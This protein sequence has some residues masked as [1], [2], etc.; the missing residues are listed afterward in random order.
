MNRAYPYLTDKQL[1]LE[2]AIG[3]LLNG[4][5]GKSIAYD[6]AIKWPKKF[7]ECRRYDTNAVKKIA[8]KNKYEQYEQHDIIN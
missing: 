1:K 5:N 2:L 6:V 7:T 3:H 8:E 4:L